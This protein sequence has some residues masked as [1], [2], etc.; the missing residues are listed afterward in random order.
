MPIDYQPTDKR[1]YCKFSENIIQ[2]QRHNGLEPKSSLYRR[3][4]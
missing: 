4:A 2:L 3:D 1:E